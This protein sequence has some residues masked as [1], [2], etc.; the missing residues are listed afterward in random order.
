MD[1][2]LTTGLVHVSAT[3]TPGAITCFQIGARPHHLPTSTVADRHD[4][5]LAA[6][7]LPA[8]A[9]APRILTTSHQQHRPH[10]AIAGQTHHLTLDHRVGQM[11]QGRACC[12]LDA[13]P[14]QH[15]EDFILA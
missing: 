11:P 8:S 2:L 12:R 14:R 4:G 10:T 9:P 5:N 6:G 7:S 3:V 13:M 1:S 15:R